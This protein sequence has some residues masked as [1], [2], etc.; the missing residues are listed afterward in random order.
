MRLDGSDPLV[1]LLFQVTGP[2][3]IPWQD[4]VWQ[5]LLYGYNVWVHC[6]NADN[7]ALLERAAQSNRQHCERTS[8]LAALTIHVTGSLKDLTAAQQKLAAGAMSGE[9]NSAA[10]PSRR[11]SSSFEHISSSS[12]SL[13]DQVA[14]FSNRISLVGKARATAGALNLLRILA[15][16]VIAESAPP[17]NQQSTSSSLDMSVDS[18]GRRRRRIPE[19]PLNNTNRLKESFCYKSRE[20]DGIVRDTAADLMSA[21]LQFICHTPLMSSDIL[22]ELYDCM[23]LALQ[24]LIVLLGTQLYQPLASSFQR[25]SP[26][27]Q[28]PHD[29]FWQ[30]LLTQ[31]RQNSSANAVWTPCQL[32]Q[33]LLNWHVQRPAAPEKS[34]QHHACALAEQVVTAKGE[35]KSGDGLYESYWVVQAAAP[36]NLEL[37]QDSSTNGVARSAP[38]R[39]SSHNA[40]LDATRGALVF[41][42]QIILLPFRLMSLALHLWGHLVITL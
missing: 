18:R 42:S 19:G 7:N 15:H 12:Q 8:N 28:R 34:I 6:S 3:H 41:S 9:G 33:A 4:L 2:A 36:P 31:S 27:E 5:E 23:V 26:D 17:Q 29:Y 40:L 16:P 35:K 30:I 1:S 11:S 39:A 14:A 25:S 24:L 32:L 10:I 20:S 21:L 38:R 37:L 13:G 22:P